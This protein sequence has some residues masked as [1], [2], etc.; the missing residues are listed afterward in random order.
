MTTLRPKTKQ[1][2][3]KHYTETPTLLKQGVFS[4]G[5][6]SCSTSGVRRVTPLIIG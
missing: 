1:C 4:K 3:L 2:L 6:G 5:K